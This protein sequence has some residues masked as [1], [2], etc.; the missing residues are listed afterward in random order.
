MMLQNLMGWDDLSKFLG[1]GYVWYSFLSEWSSG[2]VCLDRMFVL[3]FLGS[4]YLMKAAGL[5][6]FRWLCSSYN[7]DIRKVVWAI[8]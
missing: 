6:F 3:S 4:H 5:V 7:W 2:F 1:M 8:G